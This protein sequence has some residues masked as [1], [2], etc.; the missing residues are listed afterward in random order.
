MSIVK[1]SA[2][3][4]IRVQSF[5]IQNYLYFDG[6]IRLLETQAA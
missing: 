3:I 1:D 4:H 2:F 5:E 6:S